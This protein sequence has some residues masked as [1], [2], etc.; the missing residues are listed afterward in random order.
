MHYN[1]IKRIK[2]HK[3]KKNWVAISSVIGSLLISS[4]IVLSASPIS[5]QA[6]TEVT[7]KQENNINLKESLS[8]SENV[9][10]ENTNNIDSTLSQESSENSTTNS[11]E[12]IVE[13][14]KDQS[15]SD[16]SSKTTNKTQE[17]ID[18]V[19]ARA[20]DVPVDTT[21]LGPNG[22]VLNEPTTTNLL[23][24]APDIDGY[25]INPEATIVTAYTSDGSDPTVY[26]FKNLL[27]FFT[28]QLQLFI[29][30]AHQTI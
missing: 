3:V 27:D 20:V 9:D 24:N 26:V 30:V 18:T 22:E 19:E 29:M 15:K 13:Q 10:T 11:T 6:E 14:Q 25:W 7:E 2:M 17:N 1:P 23:P 28:K 16:D 21:Y 5:V 8:T 4:S 12:P